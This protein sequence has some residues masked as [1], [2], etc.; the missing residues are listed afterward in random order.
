MKNVWTFFYRDIDT[1]TKNYYSVLNHYMLIMLSIRFAD[2]YEVFNSHFS[3]GEMI[4][5]LVPSLRLRRYKTSFTVR[6]CDISVTNWQLCKWTAARAL[7]LAMPVVWYCVQ[8]IPAA[9]GKTDF[10]CLKV[11]VQSGRSAQWLE[12]DWKFR[13]EVAPRE[14]IL[15]SVGLNSAW[16][17]QRV[18]I[19][20]L[21][22][23]C[24]NTGGIH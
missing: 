19:F 16:C 5:M 18:F 12:A 23:L 21:R 14:G 3:F 4:N 7:L 2:L 11:C 6:I 24:L 9:D 20:N 22:L 1:L 17:C 15:F 13:R 10:L 8:T